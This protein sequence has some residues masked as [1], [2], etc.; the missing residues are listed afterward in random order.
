M[1]R[2]PQ[3]VLAHSWDAVCV[4]R[5]S[6]Y[7]RGLNLFVLDLQ[8][9]TIY[10]MRNALLNEDFIRVATSTRIYAK[11]QRIYEFSQTNFS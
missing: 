4:V 6:Q 1:H 8:L 9:Y 5:H 7:F 10:S 11:V 2:T 3:I